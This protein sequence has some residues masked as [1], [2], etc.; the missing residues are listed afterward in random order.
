MTETRDDG[1]VSDGVVKHADSVERAEVS[2]GSAT[3]S[4]RTSISKCS[5][6]ST[7]ST[8]HCVVRDA[9]SFCGPDAPPEAPV[10]EPAMKRTNATPADTVLGA[11][12]IIGNLAVPSSN[13]VLVGTV[14]C[15]TSIRLTG[16]MNVT[17]WDGGSLRD[18]VRKNIGAVAVCPVGREFPCRRWITWV[19]S[20]L[21][22]PSAFVRH[23]QLL[24]QEP[25][26]GGRQVLRL[27]GR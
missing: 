26:N 2:A 16:R 23:V 5:G 3:P 4:S 21:V 22:Q 12:S 15:P 6:R 11:R 9:A 7:G 20:M 17:D 27:G 10:P 19:E 13:A 14:G 1:A 25:L 8:N 24:P 18:L